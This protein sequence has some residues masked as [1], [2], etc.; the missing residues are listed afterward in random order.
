[1]HNPDNSIVIRLKD[2]H[3]VRLIIEVEDPLAT[4]ATIR[5]ALGQER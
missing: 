5:R 4:V 1:M 3:Y 2:E